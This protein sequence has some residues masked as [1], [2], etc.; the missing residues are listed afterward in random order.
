MTDL[1]MDLTAVLPPEALLLLLCQ[2][3]RSLKDHTWEFLDL[4]H[5]ADFPD[6]SLV[7]F[8]LTLESINH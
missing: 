5:Q 1:N 2:G 6:K 4:A 7:V 3:D 8:F